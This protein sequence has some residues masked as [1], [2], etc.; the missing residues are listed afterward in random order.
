MR[1]KHYH[2]FQELNAVENLNLERCTATI[3]QLTDGN[4]IDTQ[5]EL[6]P[7]AIGGHSG[8]TKLSS[9]GEAGPVPERQAVSGSYRAKCRRPSSN[10]RREWEDLDA[11]SGH[12]ISG[13]LDLDAGSTKSMK[14]L[15]V[16]HSRQAPARQVSD[17]LSATGFLLDECK[18]DARVED[19]Y[20]SAAASARRC[21][22]RS[23]TS[24]PSASTYRAKTLWT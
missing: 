17:D 8:N 9:G 6:G 11:Q 3:W 18:D 24:E 13:D 15:C 20:H 23:S 21:A 4:H 14:D 1:P 5:V 12:Q 7:H 2:L 10:V 22:I 16:V 19:R